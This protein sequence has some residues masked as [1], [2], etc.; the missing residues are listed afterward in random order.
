ME[1]LGVDLIVSGHNHVYERFTQQDLP[2]LCS[3]K[4]IRSVIPGTG[5]NSHIGFRSPVA[6]NRL[7]RIPNTGCYD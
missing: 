2:G 6:P 5:G 7:V 1:V 3:T 4:G